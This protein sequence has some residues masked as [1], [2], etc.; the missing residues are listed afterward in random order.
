MPDYTSTLEIARPAGDRRTAQQWARAVWEDAPRPVR[1]FLRVGWRC[2]GLRADPAPERV[3][4]WTVAES[5]PDHVVLTVPARIMTSRNVVRLDE[6][7]VRWTTDVDFDRS[8]ARLLWSLAVPFH[9]RLIP[10]RLRRVAAGTDRGARQHRIVTR[11]QRH[12]GNPLVSRL[13]GQTLLETTGRR[14]GLPRRT[15]LGGR[16]TGGQFW[17][18]SEFGLRSH[19]VRNIEA[20]PHVRLRLHGRWHRGVAHL[21]PEDDARARLKSLPRLNSAAVRTLGADLLTIR[22]DLE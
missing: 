14:S 16:R 17:L 2:L 10:A 6:T 5:G 22:V 11:F 8:P 19:Y 9:R 21:L 12:L 3:L 7:H 20:D 1:T 18:V 4:G 13:P 15:P